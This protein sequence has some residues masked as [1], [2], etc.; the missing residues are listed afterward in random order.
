MAGLT[1]TANRPLVYNISAITKNNYTRTSGRLWT[2]IFDAQC[3]Q[4]KISKFSNGNQCKLY[5]TKGKKGKC[6]NIQYTSKEEQVIII[7][8]YWHPSFSE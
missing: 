5:G 8:I 4:K 6:L 7:I 2:A 3:K 1:Q